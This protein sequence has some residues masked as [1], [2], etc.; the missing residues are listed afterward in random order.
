MDIT[1][2]FCT[3]T[4]LLQQCAWGTLRLFIINAHF[5]EV[6]FLGN[7]LQA[8]PTAQNRISNAY[9]NPNLPPSPF[10]GGAVRSQTTV[11]DIF[12]IYDAFRKI[13]AVVCNQAK[14]LLKSLLGNWKNC[15]RA[16]YSMGIPCEISKKFSRG[17]PCEIFKKSLKFDR[18]VFE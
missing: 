16:K 11:I 5:V 17:V 10:V 9:A 15:K 6:S 7:Y 14:S 3:T 12:I 1:T 18:I 2:R 4:R 8:P 13:I